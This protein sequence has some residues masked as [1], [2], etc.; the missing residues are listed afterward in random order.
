MLL[1][2]KENFFQRIRIVWLDSGSRQWG[3]YSMEWYNT[4]EIQH[5]RI[6][7]KKRFLSST[8]G[9]KNCRGHYRISSRDVQKARA[10]NDPREDRV[11]LY[12]N[13]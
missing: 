4:Y 11:C 2:V 6:N 7:G 9:L 10:Q 12:V 5:S 13:R 8:Y 3:A 1:L